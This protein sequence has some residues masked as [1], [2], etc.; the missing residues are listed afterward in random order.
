MW[1]SILKAKQMNLKIFDF[2]GSML[3]NVERYFREFGGNLVPY[4]S[5]EK[6]RYW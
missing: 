4:Y 5:C 3:P 2:E 1:K 6:F